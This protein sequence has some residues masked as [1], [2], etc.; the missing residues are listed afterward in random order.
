MDEIKKVSVII[1]TYK[2][3]ARYLL[4]SI[5]SIK[6]Q[7]YKNIEII[8]VDDNPD[9][10]EY[11]KKTMDFM[12]QFRDD[13][14]VIY[15]LNP[16]NVGGALSRNNGIYAA[17]GDYIT[18]LDDDDEYLPEK[19]KKQL[20]FMIETDCDMSFTNL[21][22]V[23]ENKTVIDYREHHDLSYFD[24]TSLLRYHLTKQITGTP[25]FMY[26]TD[27]LKLIGGFDDVK[28]GQEYYL[29]V[30]TIENDLNIRYIDDCDVI[31][32]RHS[33]GGISFGKNKINGE[34]KLFEFKKKYF[35]ILTNKEKRYIKFRHLVILSIGYK[36]NKN[37]IY[38][39]KYGIL[40][41]IT[42]PPDFFNE[43][44][45]FIA[46]LIKQRKS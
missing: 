12:Q 24:K 36:R 42:S 37:I 46:N 27:K 1:P 41:V 28:M 19:I 7:T 21:K 32:Y 6:N 2:R 29:M 25:T 11:R 40:A 39:L 45:R 17:T 14:D 10:S 5:E 38:M 34:N 31:A 22:L 35:N 8:V 15:M 43:T 16:K 9:E 18:F 30:K 4:R 23:N 3:D 20:K 26:K 13:K 44:R 33:D